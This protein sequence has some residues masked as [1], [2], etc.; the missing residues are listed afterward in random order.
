MTPGERFH[1]LVV[2]GDVGKRTPCRSILWE[3]ICDCGNTIHTRS[4]YLKNGRTK[5]CGCLGREKRLAAHTKH[6]HSRRG[7]MSSEMTCYVHMLRRCNNPKHTSYP[8]YGGRGIK[9]CERWTESFE[10]FFEDMGRRPSP[11]HS[12]D[13]IDNEKG[14]SKSNCRWA[15]HQQQMRNTRSVRPVRRSDGVEYGTTVEAAI[16]TGVHA[17]GIRAAAIGKQKTS[18][19]YGWEFIWSLYTLQ[20]HRI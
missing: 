7:N 14:Y 4:K 12:L 5:S 17:T 8:R 18:G 13:R 2:V 20:T 15:T 1:R 3:C 16:D 10:N 11:M 19:G 6:G 9:V